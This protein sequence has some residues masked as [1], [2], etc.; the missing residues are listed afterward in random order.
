M[1]VI[2]LDGRTYGW[3]LLQKN[4]TFRECSYGHERA[5]TLIKE[6]FPIDKIYEEEGLPGTKPTLFADFI[7]PLRK[8]LIEVHGKQHYEWIPYFHTTRK[9]F[10]D[11]QNR[12]RRKREWA[13]I[14]HFSYIE[15]PDTEDNNGWRR[16]ILEYSP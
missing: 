15:L 11:A 13:N 7:I 16:R 6:L 14:N 9:D 1:K 4:H 3:E 12:D 8:L 10:I 5:R 2:G